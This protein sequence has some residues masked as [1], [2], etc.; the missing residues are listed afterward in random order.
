[1]ELDVKSLPQGPSE[2]VLECRAV[3]LDMD[4][5]AATFEDRVVARF[6]VTRHGDNVLIHGTGD[7]TVRSDCARCLEPTRQPL[8]AEFTA[9]AERRPVGGTKGLDRELEAD[10]YIFFHDG[11][12]LEVGQVVREA[13]LLALPLR[14]LCR[15]DCR[16]LCPGC[17]ANLNTEPC[18]CATRAGG[19]GS[20]EM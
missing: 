11:V 16:G 2:T 17:G 1:M 12:R 10:N 15:P 14:F 19:A 7:A 8:T 6:R 9:Y 5:D 20:V 3:E 18:T 4:S 13:L